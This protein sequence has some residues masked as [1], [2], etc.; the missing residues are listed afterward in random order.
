M[1]KL[2]PQAQTIIV[3]LLVIALVLF[4]VPKT[5]EGF[6]GGSSACQLGP[7]CG[8]GGCN[9]GKGGCQCGGGCACGEYDYPYESQAEHPPQTLEKFSSC[10]SRKQIYLQSC[11]P[12]SPSNHAD[13]NL[14]KR[15]GK[16][17]INIQANL[18]YALGG[19]FHTAWGAYHAFLVDSKTKKSIN[20]GS[21][22]RH[23]DRWYKLSTE[24]LGEYSNYDEIVIYRVTEDYAPRAVLKSSIKQ[25]MCSSL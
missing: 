22:V 2:P 14:E 18:P 7:D 17:Y 16:L 10:Y 23:G 1:F 11:D 21:L 13:V 19:V 20:L 24:L 15:W 8:C 6:L 5:Q 3:V 4:F 12:D 25:Q 9:G